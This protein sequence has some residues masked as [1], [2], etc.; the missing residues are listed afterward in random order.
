MNSRRFLS[1]VFGVVFLSSLFTSCDAND[2]L[3]IEKNHAE[4]QAINKDEIKDSDV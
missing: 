1:L 2:T 3:E 4:L